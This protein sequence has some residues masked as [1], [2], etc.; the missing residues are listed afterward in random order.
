VLP[1]SRRRAVGGL[2]AVLGAAPRVV[3]R[4]VREVGQRDLTGS[5]LARHDQV[6]DR[7]DLG[8]DGVGQP[9]VVEA[10]VPVRD[11]VAGSIAEP[12]QVD[13]LAGPVA[14]QRV[15]RDDTQTNQGEP[16]HDE[17][18][19]VQQLHD[20]PLT[21][22]QPEPA[23]ASDQAVDRAVQLG[24]AQPAAVVDDCGV[25]AGPRGPLPQE[26]AESPT[27]PVTGQP[28]ALSDL[29][30]PTQMADGRPSGI[31]HRSSPPSPDTTNDP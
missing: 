11:D 20:D 15:H 24:V 7:R 6:P 27:L 2:R 14:R 4:T 3:G 12:G 8:T 9:A 10:G 29:R 26:R 19:G 31:T 21:P 22:A 17:V 23:Q 1:S 18:G 16:H 25:L 5:G 13:D 30:R 28:V